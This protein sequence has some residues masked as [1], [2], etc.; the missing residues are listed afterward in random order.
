MPIPEIGSIDYVKY[1][2]TTRI[3][4]IILRKKSIS[5]TQ[6][7]SISGLSKVT[8]S[9]CI[10]ILRNCGLVI[11]TGTVDTQRGRRPIMLTINRDAGLILSVETDALFTR[12]LITDFLGTPLDMVEGPG[13]D[14]PDDFLDWLKQEALHAQK[15]YPSYPG[16]MGIAI[17]LAGY[18][19]SQDGIISYVATRKKWTGYPLRARLHAL[20]PDISFCVER[21]ANAGALG[22]C[23][24]DKK[25]GRS[26][27]YLSCSWGMGVGLTV[28]DSEGNDVLNLSSRFGHVTI[29]RHGRECDCG[30]RGCLEAYASIHALY[31]QIYPGESIDFIHYQDLFRRYIQKDPIVME[32][33]RHICEALTIGIVNV[34]NAYQPQTICIGGA[35]SLFLT[36]ENLAKMMEQIEQSVPETFRKGLCLCISELKEK[37]PAY[38]GVALIQNRILEYIWD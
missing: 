8:V 17:V 38:G 27:A 21:Q 36:E 1:L 6:I 26:L 3:Y 11:E 5:R 16:I 33:L 30:N 15:Q 4:R 28:G 20:F 2:N 37:A 35:L 19:D 7:A 22:V 18:Y 14:S 13:I 23:A 9:S 32:E 25:D 31:T 10:D 29:N 34:I 24:F 12:L